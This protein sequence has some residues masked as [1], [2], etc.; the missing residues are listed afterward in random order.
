MD[1]QMP[2]QHSVMSGAWP[3]ELDHLDV[4]DKVQ[5]LGCRIEPL[6]QLINLLG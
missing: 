4:N 2:A 1:F 3:H 5:L 6:G